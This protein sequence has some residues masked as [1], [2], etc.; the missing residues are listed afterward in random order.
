[1]PRGAEESRFRE[2]VWLLNR[3]ALDLDA[4]EIADT[5]WLAQW[6]PAA[7]PGAGPPSAGPEGQPGE[8][9]VPGASG[10]TSRPPGGE[11]P[12]GGADESA[13][14]SRRAAVADDSGTGAGGGTG[15]SGGTG[16]GGGAGD[17][18]G[19]ADA[20]RPGRLLYLVSDQDASPRRQGG[21]VGR[22]GLPAEAALPAPLA[23]QRALRPLRRYRSRTLPV[24]GGLDET[25][26]AERSAQT[27][28]LMPVWRPAPAGG[29]EFQLLLD[30]GGQMAVWEPMVRQL[31]S[32]IV[33]LG[34]F[35]RVSV[36]YLRALPPGSRQGE[37][38][39]CADRHGE[40]SSAASLGDAAGRRITLL[41]SDG[42]G[43]LWRSG[44][45][46]P[47][48]RRWADQAPLAWLQPLPQRLWP[49]AELPVS[50]AL[51]RRSAGDYRGLRAVAGGSA[52]A[53]PLP[54]LEPGPAAF[55]AWARLAAADA[56]SSMWFPTAFLPADGAGPVG[57]EPCPAPC[58]AG[59]SRN[60]APA[61]DLLR[62]FERTAS[63]EARRLAM[64][65]SAV[66][67]T[68]PVILLVQRA[69]L[70]RSG[71]A[72][73]AEVLTSELLLAHAPLDLAP[74]PD[75]WF[76][77]QPG[78]RAA[79]RDRLTQSEAA[80]VLQCAARYIE[81]AFGRG[82][83]NHPAV[84][85]ARLTESEGVAFA[86]SGDVPAPFAAVS[87]EVLRHFEPRG[88]LQD[89]HVSGVAAL[90]GYVQYGSPGDLLGALS[91]LRE[92]R[93]ALPLDPSRALWLVRALRE[94]WVRWRDQ[95]SLDEADMVAEH[96]LA[97]RTG[98]A[99][100]GSPPAGPGIDERPDAHR[101]PE[102]RELLEPEAGRP[103][104]P[105]PLTGLRQELAW[106][107]RT[108]GRLLLARSDVHAARVDLLRAEELCRQVLDVAAGPVP[109]AADAAAVLGD[110][111]LAQWE[112]E[113]LW[114]E[115]LPEEA[116]AEER[117]L[118]LRRAERELRALGTRWPSA[119]AP[120]RLCCALGRLLLAHVREP[121][122][123]DPGPAALLY[124]AQYWLEAA[125]A[126][127]GDD[128]DG[129]QA[130][131]ALAEV[132]RARAPGAADGGEL[133]ARAVAMLERDVVGRP[134]GPEATERQLLVLDELARLHEQAFEQF[135][136][137]AGL[138]RAEEVLR[139]ALALLSWDDPRRA[140]LNAGRGRVL[141]A[142][143]GADTLDEAVTALRLAVEDTHADSPQDV[144][145]RV[146]LARACLA[147]YRSQRR[148]ADAYE[149][150]WLL[151][152]AGHS[153]AGLRQQ[154]EIGLELGHACM[155]L[156]D[157]TGVHQELERA[158]R[159]FARAGEA[160]RQAG[161]PVLAA[162]A[163]HA[164][165]EALEILSGRRRAQEAYALAWRLWNEAGEAGGAE[166]AR[167]RARLAPRADRDAADG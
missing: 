82:A 15:T 155:E 29:T 111:L 40:V 74:D 86:G 93:S 153:A 140:R 125:V 55:A 41:V 159:S 88:S 84:V 11:H 17:R 56:G 149:A 87:E 162:R 113:R 156:A 22:I 57:R 5:L 151:A 158:V 31:R 71:P 102:A 135:A 61:A 101:P 121:G 39:V 119:G 154:A 69:M 131:A 166:A 24:R 47:L 20:D 100:L 21:A 167:T 54:V 96:V 136:D 37:V 63:P 133:L 112:A 12:A 97:G 2:T 78:V 85:V 106:V 4:R 161:E 92:A 67:L 104:E 144:P 147:R 79:L 139:E 110:V 95:D 146:A 165:G 8:E 143:G 105:D 60:R 50:R 81:R 75:T 66:A 1:M 14:G 80:L 148:M 51:L 44:V 32:L 23:L 52:A 45:L 120:W 25:A 124:E 35:R 33:Q 134:V 145:R 164:R 68:L 115:Q 76:E 73:L 137:A 118:L 53:V 142:A 99:P 90:N 107:L 62:R 46:F 42:T 138:V 129:P 26:T 91:L 6:L 114:A 34:A 127:S 126:G 49:R 65:L 108:R 16:K 27:A 13:A 28:V 98:P 128:P 130:R 117:L 48:L 64:Y 77:F 58:M 38:G 9:G 103:L 152:Q 109:L 43:T 36:R 10:P 3:A 163:H 89:A 141:L 123:K 19:Q 150:Q 160:A 72:V 18:R 94:S 70:P 122:A 30:A 83:R 7:A 157:R 116:G 59:D 132:L